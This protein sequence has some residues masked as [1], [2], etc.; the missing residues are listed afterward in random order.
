MPSVAKGVAI[1]IGFTILGS[2]NYIFLISGFNKGYFFTIGS[3]FSSVK[4]TG[5][6]PFYVFIFF[7]LSSSF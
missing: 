3:S 2:G 6:L 5:S 4:M 7:R 1:T